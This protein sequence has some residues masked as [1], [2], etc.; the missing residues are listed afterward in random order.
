MLRGSPSVQVNHS[1]PGHFTTDLQPL[2]LCLQ[3]GRQQP[4]PAAWEGAPRAQGS[5]VLGWRNPQPLELV[6]AVAIYD[7]P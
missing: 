6:R 5:T 3:T 2:K 4:Q 7:V 1:E